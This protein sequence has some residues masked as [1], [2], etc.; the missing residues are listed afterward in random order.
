M[1]R[2]TPPHPPTHPTPPHEGNK[3]LTD[4]NEE[5][6]IVL[7]KPDALPPE[8]N[9]STVQEGNSRVQLLKVLE[10]RK[11]VLQKEQGMAFARAV[12]A[13][14]DID[15][16]APLV[17]FAE[18][19]GASRLMD[20]CR[21][22]VDL[23]KGKH[24]TGQWLEI[25][26]AEAMSCRS[27]FSAM[28]ASGIMLSSVA[29]K[30]KEPLSD[31]P[32]ENNGKAG[33]EAT[34]GERH[35]ADHQ[36]PFGQQE[37]FQGQFPHPMFPAWP[38]HSP[39]GTLPVFQPYPVQG[40]PYYPNYPGNGPFYPPPYLPMEDSRISTGHRTRQRRQSA[41]GRD[42]S[43]GSEASETDGTNARSQ[44]GMELEKEGS[45]RREPR[46]KTGRSGKKQS[47]VVVIRNINYIAS[48]GQNSS[49]SVSQSGSDSDT[50]KESGDLQR[51]ALDMMHKNSMESNKNC[52]S[53][54]DGSKSYTEESIIHGKE[55]DGGHWQAFQNF[56]LRD[57]DEHDQ[58]TDQGLFAMEK[59]LKTK[60]R[61]RTVAD[62][63]LAV[64]GRDQ[65]EG[66][67]GGFS[68]FQ[69]LSGNLTRKSGVS[70][71]EILMCRGEGHFDDHRG[72]T[73][74][75]MDVQFTEINGRKVMYR[76]SANDDF[77]VVGHENHSNLVSSSDLLALD[78]LTHSASHLNKSSH[79]KMTD[80]S[81]IVPLR[82]MSLDQV[83][84]GGRA[85]IDIDS[86]LPKTVQKSEIGPNTTPNGINYEP[87]DL[88]LMPE[89]GTEKI[90]IGYDPAL[91]YEMEVCV[92]DAASMHNSKEVAADVKKGP[93]KS[94]KDQKS[95]VTPGTLDKKSV[96][97]IRKVKPSKL[98]PLEDARARADRLRAFKADLQKMKKEKLESLFSSNGLMF[99]LVPFAGRRTAKATGSFK[100]REAKENCSKGSSVVPQSPFS[101]QTARKSSTKLSVTS[102]RVSKFSDSEPGSSSPLQ[103]SKLRTSSLGSS[104]SR[105]VS[106]TSKSNNGNQ[107]PGN[108]LT[109]SAS[110]LP[111][112]RKESSCVTPDLKASKARIR[113][114]SEPKTSST[115][116][117]SSTESQN[118]ELISKPKMSKEPES[119]KISAI[120][121]LDRS[122]AATL[123]ELR[124][125]KN[126]DSVDAGQNKH[127]AKEMIQK[128]N[129]SKSSATCSNKTDEKTHQSDQVNSPVIDKTVVMLGC[130]KPSLPVVCVS[131][132][133]MGVQKEHSNDHGKVEKIEMI[134]EY[135][136]RAPPSPMDGVNVEPIQSQL[137]EQP[138]SYEVHIEKVSPKSSNICKAGEPYQAPVA[139]LSSLEDPST[140]HL[141]YGKAPPMSSE[142][143][144]SSAGIAKV[145]LSGLD[146]IKLQKIPESVGR[147]QVK[148]SPKGFRRLLKFGRKNHSSSAGELSI[149]SDNA[150]VNGSEVDDNATKAASSSEGLTN[151]E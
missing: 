17:S 26:A 146:N 33:I 72:S 12:A 8:T 97:P 30:Q 99:K 145:Q 135:T 92:E 116:Y 54:A 133:N 20:A 38:A 101:Q 7:Y 127:A 124:I 77:M 69:K 68:E 9:G 134:P 35:P 22:F 121:S 31:V 47:G 119:R 81:F 104:E 37:Y 94:E 24:E 70:N 126:K 96:G 11:T 108:R 55:A 2:P 147:L 111:E 120:I 1:P 32:P 18:C 16:I 46:K 107:V 76:G 62:D 118:T 150:S 52:K 85:A 48:K 6:A 51:S 98:N 90:T 89:R 75:K 78:G 141:E 45:H 23:W 88:S 93:K 28:N 67:D 103:R 82:S 110:S 14:F 4:T 41:D 142:T 132:E 144:K 131:E 53:S 64:V 106:K 125:R 27:D 79:E 137:Q 117:V 57:T 102:H 139:R 113:R 39:P 36:V 43:T 84:A 130:E 42:S 34:S 13:G 44:G 65:I 63:P 25:E 143:M 83:G 80:E 50:D 29:N 129:Q 128:V 140:E 74:D 40:M 148:E 105:K 10:A 15:H 149:E 114:L 136:V 86:E 138:R 109:R 100:D 73:D 95:R 91:D 122:K 3:S 21:R 66:Q 5:R 60:R 49:E 58:S 59:N 56:L 87:D 123:P 151:V 115:P 19:F 71:D 112:T 61:Q